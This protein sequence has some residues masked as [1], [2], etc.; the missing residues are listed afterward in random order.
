MF[1]LR[2]N[3]QE[4][5]DLIEMLEKHRTEGEDSALAALRHKI[6]NDFQSQFSQEE[7][8]AN[9][10]DEDVLKNASVAMGPSYCE[11]CD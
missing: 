9:I 2:L 3:K 5:M 8:A 1:N 6:K 11:T 4:C 7:R 10:T